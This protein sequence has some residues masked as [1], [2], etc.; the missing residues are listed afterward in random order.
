MHHWIW[1]EVTCHYWYLF[2]IW[3]KVIVTYY[4]DCTYMQR[5][6]E[7]H[8]PVCLH[9]AIFWHGVGVIVRCTEQVSHCSN[10]ITAVADGKYQTQI[11][12][13]RSSGTATSTA[14]SGEPPY[15]SSLLWQQACR[16]YVLLY[17]TSGQQGGILLAYN[18]GW[19]AHAHWQ[20][21]I[22]W[23]LKFHPIILS[24]YLGCENL[25]P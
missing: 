17:L 6:L 2:A 1:S 10:A 14:T 23:R 15:S 21:A 16:P 7:M 24:T 3:L 11:Q 20:A 9:V 4:S 25:C 22:A 12:F 13:G 8:N 5:Y 19:I 18:C